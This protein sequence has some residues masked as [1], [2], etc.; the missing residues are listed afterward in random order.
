M[1]AVTI[2]QRNFFIQFRKIRIDIRNQKLTLKSLVRKTFLVFEKL[3]SQWVVPKSRQK[4]IFIIIIINTFFTCCPRWSKVCS[5]MFALIPLAFW[6][7]ICSCT[8]WWFVGPGFVSTPSIIRSAAMVVTFSTKKPLNIVFFGLF[9]KNLDVRT[10]KLSF[11]DSQSV[12]WYSIKVSF[13]CYFYLCYKTNN[14]G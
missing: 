10:N 1:R 12:L 4:A 3:S 11:L 8:F 13:K 14:A 6:V 7:M 2:L 5:H 9:R